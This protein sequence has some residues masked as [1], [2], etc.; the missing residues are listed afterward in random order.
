[1]TTAADNRLAS[2]LAEYKDL[3]VQMG[4]PAL[5]ADPAQARRVGRRYAEL[6][7]IAK[8][9]EDIEAA[10]DDLE[11][12]EE[13]AKEDSDFAA[14][15]EGLRQRIP[16]LE[17][18][19]AELLVPRDPDDAKDVII[20]IKAGAGGEESGLFAGDLMRMYLRY[21]ERQGYAVETL[22]MVPTDLGGIKDSSIAVRTKGTP[23]GGNGVW[24]R[25][26]FEGGVHRVQRVPVTESQ[27]RVHTSA[28]AV[29]VMPE[30]EEV[31]FELNMNDVRVDVYRSSGPGGQSVN[32]TDSAVR[33]T[34]VP[35][36]VVVTSQNEKS[37]LQNK[38][39][40]IKVLRARLLAKQQEEAAAAAG[41]AR[42]SQVR[43]ADRSE[44]IRT[45]NF[46]QNRLT[47]HRVGFTAY[48]LD[49]VMDGALDE[50]LDALAAADRAERMARG[51]E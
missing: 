50:V 18:K 11:T 17:E 32:T 29:V 8:T 35:T 38:E 34:H 41:A 27:G 19:L 44:R 25:M 33:L 1:M 12:A 13:L 3:E 20:E 42:L 7:P 36:G 22:E 5:H 2:L 39:A 24:S 14:E 6:S 47:D 45:Y 10:K 40:A 9:A 48:N 30:A 16:V 51:A 37:Q 23:E 28:A 4:D 49:Q 21:F 43:T 26:K 31:D 46:P 15:A